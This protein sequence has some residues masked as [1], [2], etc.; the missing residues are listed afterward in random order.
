MTNYIS[1]SDE[2]LNDNTDENRAGNFARKSIAKRTNR[3]SYPFPSR[4]NTQSA[5]SL[6]PV[7]G[8]PITEEN[9]SENEEISAHIPKKTAPRQHRFNSS[10]CRLS[11]IHS[12]RSSYSSSDDDDH[13]LIDKKILSHS[14][15][16]PS[17][18]SGGG[19]GGQSDNTSDNNTSVFTAKSDATS[20]MDGINAKMLSLLLDDLEQISARNSSNSKVMLKNLVN[21]AYGRHLSD[22]NLTTYSL[23]LQLVLAT[24]KLKSLQS[25]TTN[26]TTS[27]TATQKQQRHHQSKSNSDTNL[28]KKFCK[29]KNHIIAADIFKTKEMI[30]KYLKRTKS[31]SK[32]VSPISLS[33]TIQEEDPITTHSNNIVPTAT[34][35]VSGSIDTCA[36]SQTFSDIQ[37]LHSPVQPVDEIPESHLSSRIKSDLDASTKYQL[38]VSEDALLNEANHLEMDDSGEGNDKVVV[39]ENL[40]NGVQSAVA[41][42]CS[43][44]LVAGV[45][46]AV[47]TNGSVCCSLV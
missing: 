32:S 42:N 34:S 8:E 26:T 13:F 23:Q 29:K 28:I 27:T 46:S 16:T 3:M 44:N 33:D 31:G 45:Q 40:V 36:V 41:T 14:A 17:N 1:H 6:L 21:N 22:T 30:F 19:D 43:V 11:P 38:I 9:E 15:S 35:S 25:T 12:R 18:L 24:E 2:S 4:N 7:T 47:A 39:S 37:Q 20:S 5:P 10:S